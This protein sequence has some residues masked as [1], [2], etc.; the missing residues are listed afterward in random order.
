MVDLMRRIG[1]PTV[2]NVAQGP[3]RHRPDDRVD[4]IRHHHPGPQFI[5]LSVKKSNCPG[6]NPCQFRL[7]QMTNAMA[8]I[9]IFVHPARIPPE[10]LLLL[11]PGQRTLRGLGLA[12][13]S[14]ALLFELEQHLFRQRARLAERDKISSAFALQ[15]RQHPARVQ[16]RNQMFFVS[17][18]LRP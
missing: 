6:D 10:Q 17:H 3:S 11:M 1:F 14:L 8:R 15:M 9:Q 4:V 7:A 5:T 18:N 2:Q 12:E 16:S 13:N